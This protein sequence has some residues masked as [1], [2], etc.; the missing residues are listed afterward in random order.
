MLNSKDFYKEMLAIAIPIALQN[1][2]VS[3]LNTLD[4]VMISTL[5]SAAIAGVGLANQVFFF[6]SMICFGTGTGSSV[7]ISQYYGRRDFDNLKKVNALSNL[8]AFGTGIIFTLLAILIPQ[9]LIGLMIK[10]PLVIEAGAKYLRLVAL[11]YILT[12][13]SFSTGISLR[14]TGNPKAPLVAAIVGF[15]CNAF[16][17]YVFIFGKLG[18]PELGILGAAVG[19]IIARTA[20]AS[21][22]LYVS[23]RYHCPLRGRLEELFDFSQEFIQRF[24]KITLPVIINETFWGLGQIMYSVAYANVGTDATA[25]IQIVIAIQN[26]AYVLVRGLSNSCTIILGKTIG[27]GLMDAVYPYA[28]RFF[29][30][31]TLL[32]LIIALFI[33]LNPD[34]L[35]SF[36]GHLSPVVYNLS[37]TLLI[38]VGFL[39]T[40]RAF[41]SILVVGV[42]RGGGDTQYS[43]YLE[44]GSVW[45]VGVPLAFIGAVVLKLPIQWVFLMASME[46]ITKASFGLLRVR[47]KKWVHEIN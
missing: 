46:E 44:M 24:I 42:L 20:E 2:I 38:F 29:K 25:A 3:S 35:L 21:I 45:L 19:T 33:G 14:S 16:F 34:L 6:Y 13:F 47:S 26:M 7:M 18:F 28:M 43:M 9:Q 17:N 37:R 12:G 5:G 15:V 30:L 41:N 40:V 36:F 11:S 1:L 31:G 10:D 27:Q 8:I 4:T 32:A 39:F 22:L 23:T